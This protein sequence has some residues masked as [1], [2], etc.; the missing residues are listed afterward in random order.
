MET[1]EFKKRALPAVIYFEVFYL[2]YFGITL[3]QGDFAGA[4]AVAGLGVIIYGYLL[5]CRPYKYSI[6][7]KTLEFHYRLRKKQEINLM[8]IETICDPAP[9]LTKIVTDPKTLELYLENGK[10]ITVSPS[11]NLEFTSAVVSGN[12]RVNVQVSVYAQNRRVMEKKQ[13]KNRKKGIAE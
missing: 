10:R 1:V 12:K 11:S 6:T 2:I 3:Y 4:G 8:T 13:R 9:K 7:R 5:G